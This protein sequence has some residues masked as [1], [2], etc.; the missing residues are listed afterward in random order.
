MHTRHWGIACLLRT[1]LRLVTAAF[2]ALAILASSSFARDPWVWP[3]ASDSIWNTPIGDQAT[4]VDSGITDALFV[5]Y[6]DEYYA[7]LLDKDPDTAL[8]FPDGSPLWFFNTMK[9][10]YYFLSPISSGGGNYCTAFLQADGRRI[11]SF[12]PTTRET[13]GSPMRGYVIDHFNDNTNNQLRGEGRSGSHFGS[14]MSTL[15]GSLRLGELTGSQPI[16]HALKAVICEIFLYRNQ[17]TVADANTPRGNGWRWPAFNADGNTSNYNGTNTH[18][19][20]GTLLAIPRTVTDPAQIGITTEAGRKLFWALR[21]YGAYVVDVTDDWSWDP[22]WQFPHMFA[23][24]A[25]VP[26]EVQ[27]YYG[28]PLIG[29]F[30]NPIPADINRLF[31]ALKVVTN[32]DPFR[33]GGPGTRLASTAPALNA[34]IGPLAP[35]EYV[36]RA[37]NTNKC[38][39]VSGISTANGATVHLWEYVGGNNQKWILERAGNGFYRMKAR[40]SGKALDVRNTSTAGG[41]KLQQWDGSDSDN[42]LFTL[43]P[44]G[45][46]YYRIQA[47]HSGLVLDVPGGNY[48]NGIEV[49]QWRFNGFNPQKWRFDQLDASVVNGG[50]YRI[51]PQNALGKC[52]DVSG[53]STGDG[54]NVHIW[55]YGGGG[56]QKWKAITA[57]NGWWE[58]EPQHA[59]GKRL[60]VAGAGSSNGTNIIQWASNSGTAQRWRLIDRGN[61]EYQLEPQCAPGMALDVSGGVSSTANGTNVQIWTQHSNSNQRW[62]FLAP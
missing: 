58:F 15:G 17:V 31:K 62:K 39:D 24:E 19:G 16:R 36:I 60:D 38:L 29:G 1:L 45:N 22:G 61:G 44:D 54:A 2:A 47:R 21:N 34:Q 18:M 11:I 20:M 30:Q 12:Q 4:Y 7:R 57:G 23:G 42:Q 43:L 51:E 10:P 26:E 40:H 13:F 33:K 32:N 14:S 48:T 56:N 59:L 8:Q 53:V 28:T 41:A 49:Q 6:D 37:Y 9:V 3:F 5:E 25:G 46:G 50:I 27:E 52:L 35:G 55:S